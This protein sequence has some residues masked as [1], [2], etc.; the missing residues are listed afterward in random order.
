MI[1]MY[2]LWTIFW[3]ALSLLILYLSDLPL[4]VYHND[5]LINT[6]ALLGS[7]FLSVLFMMFFIYHSYFMSSLDAVASRIKILRLFHAYIIPLATACALLS[8][9]CLHLALW[10]VF[11]WLSIPVCFVF[12]LTFIYIMAML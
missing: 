2:H 9:L 5:V 7:F 6:P 11:S 12:Y 4:L 1:R 8:Y 10:G 3:T